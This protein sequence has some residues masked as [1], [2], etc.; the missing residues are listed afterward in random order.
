MTGW[1][2]MPWKTFVKR[3]E[4]QRVLR[5]EK[6]ISHPSSVHSEMSL[7]WMSIAAHTFEL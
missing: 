1:T 6:S 5:S 7:L 3:F 2:L 4:K